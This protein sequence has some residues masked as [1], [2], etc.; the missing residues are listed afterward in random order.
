MLKSTPSLQL[1]RLLGMGLLLLLLLLHAPTSGADTCPPL[2]IRL[3]AHTGVGKKNAVPTTVYVGKELIATAIVTN[4]G[5][6][7]L[8]NVA[9]GSITLPDYF[10]S[11]STHVSP[12]IKPKGSNLPKVESVRALYWLDVPL[13]AGK[14]RK[15]RV[16]ATV[17]T[18]QNTSAPALQI[19]A[20]AYLQDN[21]SVVSCDVSATPVQVQVLPAPK[22]KRRRRS[23][24]TCPPPPP[25]GDGYSFFAGG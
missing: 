7:A 16:K 8:D 20:L 19:K 6:T 17:P 14:S 9:V 11:R 15:F 25:G 1:L 4:K 23:V 10:L 24:G 2:A 13:A 18:C 12:C 21:A 22:Q 5:S 3:G